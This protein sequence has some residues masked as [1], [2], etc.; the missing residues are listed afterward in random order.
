MQR[1][2]MPRPTRRPRLSGVARNL[3]VGE[4]SAW[5]EEKCAAPL[6]FPYMPR[7]FEAPPRVSLR[8][9]LRKETTM[10]KQILRGRGRP[11]TDFANTGSVTKSE[12]A[13]LPSATGREEGRAEDEP[14][15]DF[16]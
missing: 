15:S 11:P 9:R 8:N 6:W 14:L 12:A 3:S 7:N 16:E 4:R 1:T 2:G 10:A 5:R 13:A